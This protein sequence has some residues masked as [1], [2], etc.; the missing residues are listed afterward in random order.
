MKYFFILA[1]SLLLIAGCGKSQQ[2]L[3]KE[4][5]QKEADDLRRKIDSTSK[6]IE[7]ER[8]SLDSNIK[9]IDSISKEIDKLQKKIEPGKTDKKNI[10]KSGE[11]QQENPVAEPKN[12]K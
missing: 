2:E 12:K 11:I 8:K 6:Y 10:E 9:S 7:K 4:R 5:I 1:A 3:E